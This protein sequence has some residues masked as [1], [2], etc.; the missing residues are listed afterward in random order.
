MEHF[1]ETWGYLAVFVLSFISSMGL[2][3]G[4]ELAIIYGGVLASGQITGEPHHLNVAAVILIAE[5]WARCWV[6]PPATPLGIS[7][8]VSPVDRSE[9]SAPHAQGP[10]SSRE[11]VRQTGRTSRALRTLCP[12]PSLIRLVRRWAPRRCR[13][14]NLLMFTTIGCAVWCAALTER[15]LLRL[16]SSYNSTINAFRYA[17]Y[18]A[19]ALALIAVA[20]LFWHRLRGGAFRTI[21]VADLRGRG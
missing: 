5:P 1:L 17:G 19:A 10:R 15:R 20:V 4:A 9:N 7:G 21:Q 3:V 2:P 14:V 16:G 11:L 6:P 18:V 12:P 8:A 13:S